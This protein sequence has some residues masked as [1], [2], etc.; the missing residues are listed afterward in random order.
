M[1]ESED[2]TTKSTKERWDKTGTVA[3]LV[4]VATTCA[5]VVSYIYRGQAVP[6]WASAT[7]ALMALSAVAWTFGESALKAARKSRE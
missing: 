7:F 2:D 5:V 1:S 6:I 4:L 3:A